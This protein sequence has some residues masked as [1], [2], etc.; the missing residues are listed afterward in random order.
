MADQEIVQTFRAKI[1]LADAA[2]A[3]IDATL[4]VGEG[5]LVITAADQQIGAWPVS[6]IE[7]DLTNRGYRMNVDGEHL[8]VSPVDRFTFRDAVEAERA[9]AH[10][11]PRRRWGGKAKAKKPVAAAPTPAPVEARPG[12]SKRDIKRAVQEEKRRQ[13]AA[14]HQVETPEPPAPT[15]PAEPTAPKRKLRIG[16]KPEPSPVTAVLEPETIPEPDAPWEI[17]V[18]PEPAERQKTGLAGRIEE[19]PTTWKLGAGAAIAALVIAVFFP[20]I[21]ATL[22][23]I[24]GLV[25]V[26]VAGLGLVD[27][28]YT[29]KL[30]SNLDEQRLLTGGGVL[31]A[32]GLIIITFF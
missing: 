10:S 30:P 3:D 16:R 22:M 17:P 27:P 1:G 19:L 11:T 8:L 6:S 25:A 32:I 20:R 2:D 28:A 12:P 15:A 23:L 18:T 31:L 4:T 24:P 5:R 21:I 14:A 7:L 9:A 13:A 29:R 26:M